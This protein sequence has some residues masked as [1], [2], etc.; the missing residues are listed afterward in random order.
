MNESAN[1]I[2]IG[3]KTKQAPV[4]LSSSHS[5]TAEVV[6]FIFIYLSIIFNTFVQNV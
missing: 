1:T 4:V 6:V 2:Q 5:N 3:S